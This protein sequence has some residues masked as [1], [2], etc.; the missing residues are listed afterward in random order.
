MYCLAESNPEPTA[1]DYWWRDSWGYN[2]NTQNLTIRGA[3]KN[4]TGE[5]TCI[6]NVNSKGG[7]GSLTGETTTRISVQCKYI[8]YVEEECIYKFKNK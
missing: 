5:Y 7:Y 1:G 8:F 4:H 2:H 6:V 3:S